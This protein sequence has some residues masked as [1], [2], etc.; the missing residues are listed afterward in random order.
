MSLK[1]C[2]PLLAYFLL[3]PFPAFAEVHDG[4]TAWMMIATAFVMLMT[5]GLAF[6]YAGMVR[7][8]NAVSTLYQNFIPLG[9]IGLLWAVIG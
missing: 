4:D 8:K 2:L 1:K 6:F 7:S 5:P 3:I 9:I